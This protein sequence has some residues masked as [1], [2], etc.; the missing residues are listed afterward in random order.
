[1]L[2][3]KIPLTKL[4]FNEFDDLFD[5]TNDFFPL[6]DIIENDEMYSIEL[7]LPA[8]TKEDIN[9]TIEKDNLIIEGERKKDEKI[10]YNIRES[11]FGKF[12]K[13]FSLPDDINNE[14]INAEFKNGVLR[15]KIPKEKEKSIRKTI[16][17][18]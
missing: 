12:K 13:R 7:M 6:N 9:I 2:V 11:P 3:K 5:E 14:L 15:I 18:K 17:I 8:F 16:S 4:F 1:M 10:I